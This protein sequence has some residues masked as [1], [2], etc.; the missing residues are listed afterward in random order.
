MLTHRTMGN[1]K[2]LIKWRKILR[3]NIMLNIAVH[4]HYTYTSKIFDN[5]VLP[6]ENDQTSYNSCCLSVLFIA[7]INSG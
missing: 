2:S 3:Y 5:S 6:T 1:F 7:C 4:F